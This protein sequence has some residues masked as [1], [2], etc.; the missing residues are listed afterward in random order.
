MQDNKDNYDLRLANVPKI[1]KKV[2]KG[3][4]MKMEFVPRVPTILRDLAPSTGFNPQVVW[5]NEKRMDAINLQSSAVQSD[6]L[7]VILCRSLGGGTTHKDL[8]K[9]SRTVQIQEKQNI[10]R[11]DKAFQDDMKRISNT[12][13]HKADGDYFH[14]Q[15]QIETECG[16]LV[17]LI[18]ILKSSLERRQLIEVM[19]VLW[20]IQEHAHYQRGK[21][22]LGECL[23]KV[24]SPLKADFS[25][26]SHCARL[27]LDHREVLI[28]A[29]KLRDRED[30]IIKQLT[31]MSDRLP[32][33]SRY[34]CGFKLDDWQKQVLRWIDAGKSVIIS[35]PTSS[36]KVFFLSK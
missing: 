24:S 16:S 17:L 11:A 6:N 32:P 12:E 4:R 18:K 29:K 8:E 13:S 34:T 36:G 9:E 20:A 25:S 2:R 15:N 1:W 31:D 33:L 35:A 10:I 14:I 22:E 21:R 7:D 3:R 19:D 27:I 26:L 28:R 30:M 5:E 23:R